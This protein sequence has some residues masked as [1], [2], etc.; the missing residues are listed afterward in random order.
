MF[1][2]LI[3]LSNTFPGFG[4]VRTVPERLP[5]HH[6]PHRR[7]RSS[8]ARCS[9]S[10]SGPGSSIML[11]I[12]QGKGQPIRDRRPAIAPVTKKRHAD[13]GRADDPVRPHRSRRCCGPIRPTPMSGSCC[14]SRSASAL[15][16]FYDDY[17]KVTKQTHEGFSG[18]L[19]L[20]IEAVIALVA[21]YALV[22]A[23]T[24]TPLSTSLTFPFFKDIVLQSRLVL[25]RA[26]APSSSSAP[27]MR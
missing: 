26:S 13:H 24:A 9:C 1:Y 15:I 17:L 27:A 18:K 7:R 4:A 21:C 25:R 14:W 23:R 20:L 11:R 19:R 8:P 6:L 16:G 5:L 10:C 12:R 3:E 22:R 2:W